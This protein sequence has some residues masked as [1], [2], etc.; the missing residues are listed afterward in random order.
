MKVDPVVAIAHSRIGLA[1]IHG[2]LET[3]TSPWGPA[4]RAQRAQRVPLMERVR[5]PPRVAC[6]ALRAPSL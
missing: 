5:E 4:Q 1:R 2:I 6:S 3:G